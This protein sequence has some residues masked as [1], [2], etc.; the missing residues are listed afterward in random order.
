MPQGHVIIRLAYEYNDEY[1]Y[2]PDEGGGEPEVV[3][4]DIEKAREE[5]SRLERAEWRKNFASGS[6]YGSS[7]SDYVE[8]WGIFGDVE[9]IAEE[10][11]EILNTTTSDPATKE[12]FEKRK[13]R[14]AELQNSLSGTLKG[15]ALENAIKT[16]LA[17]EF[18]TVKNSS[19]RRDA[20]R[21]LNSFKIPPD[22]S[23]EK[24]DAIRGLFSGLE[25]Y[26][27]QDIEVK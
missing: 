11:A 15:A 23:D 13:S 2:Q 19:P 16:T 27:I 12:L 4:L 9:E 14:E 20:Q 22:I 17:E 26:S 24:L 7:I 1:Y 25:F 21:F 8:D 10:L 6:S 3:F 5:W 18:P